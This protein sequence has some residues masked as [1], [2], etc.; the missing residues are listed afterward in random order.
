MVSLSHH[1]MRQN[2]YSTFMNS[3]VTISHLFDLNACQSPRVDEEFKSTRV[4]ITY[5]P[6]NVKHCSL[7]FFIRSFSLIVILTPFDPQVKNISSLWEFQNFS[8]TLYFIAA[9]GCF[10]ILFCDT[11][12]CYMLIVSNSKLSCKLSYSICSLRLF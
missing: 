6:Y 9:A 4:I 11:K 12:M 8:L 10:W 2:L 7:F 3:F 5:L 1:N